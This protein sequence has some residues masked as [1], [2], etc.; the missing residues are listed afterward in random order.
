MEPHM[1]YGDVTHG[2][3]PSRG[4]VYSKLCELLREAQDCACLMA[5][6]HQTEGNDADKLLAKGW[7]GIAELLDRLTAQITKLAANK[8]Q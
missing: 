2:G 5:H 6:L 8:L 3:T 7:L 1:K 4:L